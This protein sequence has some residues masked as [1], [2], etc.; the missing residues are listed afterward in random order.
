MD[1]YKYNPNYHMFADF[2]GLDR[3]KRM[4]HRIAQKLM[5]L[6]D[7]ASRQAGKDSINSVINH[8]GKTKKDMGVSHTGKLL[9]DTM[10]QQVRLSI[11]RHRIREDNK[12][13]EEVHKEIIRC[14]IRN[15]FSYFSFKV[16]SN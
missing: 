15:R 2:M 12:Q 13:K 10:Y 11:D 16:C 8:I 7:W 3:N 4:D 6:Y 14:N 9:V 5:L 1:T